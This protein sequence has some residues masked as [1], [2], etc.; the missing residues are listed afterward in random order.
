MFAPIRPKITHCS[1]ALSSL[2]LSLKQNF[3][4]V[5]ANSSFSKLAE[6]KTKVSTKEEEFEEDFFQNILNYQ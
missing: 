2:A 4:F 5:L 1:A 3:I 6:K